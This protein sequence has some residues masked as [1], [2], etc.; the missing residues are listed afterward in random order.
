MGRKTEGKLSMHNKLARKMGRLGILLAA[1]MAAL[2]GCV[3]K[4]APPRQHFTMQ[5]WP[6]EQPVIDITH[7]STQPLALSEPKV[8]EEG[9][10]ATL[11]Y[12]ARFARPETLRE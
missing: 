10:K 3:Q 1:A 11:I 12:S 9:E 2:P 6:D 4:D 8:L 5:T 7:P